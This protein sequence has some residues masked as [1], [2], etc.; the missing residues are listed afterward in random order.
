MD[1]KVVIELTAEEVELLSRPIQGQGGF[2]SLLRRLQAQLNDESQLVL[3]ID[4]VRQ[5][6]R[7][8]AR[9]GTGGFQGRLGAVLSALSRLADAL[10]F[11]RR[12]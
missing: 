3:R 12:R 9:Y 10:V 11:P 1:I 4:D 6:V 7:Y 8:W 2:Q 5:I